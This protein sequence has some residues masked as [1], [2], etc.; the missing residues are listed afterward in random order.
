MS[1]RGVYGGGMGKS[2]NRDNCGM[3][4]EFT[5]VKNDGKEGANGSVV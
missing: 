2:N 3:G 5:F 4:F 1:V